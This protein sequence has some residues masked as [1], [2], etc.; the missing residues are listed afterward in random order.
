MF[1]IKGKGM[2]LVPEELEKIKISNKFAQTNGDLFLHFNIERLKLSK[3]KRNRLWQIITDTSY[4]E[5]KNIENVLNTITLSKYI[6]E[7]KQI[8]TKPKIS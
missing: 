1:V 5:L 8:I 2:P 7:Q 3:Q 4:P 6:N